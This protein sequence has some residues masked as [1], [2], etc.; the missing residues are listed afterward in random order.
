MSSVF[1]DH[2]SLDAVVAYADGELSLVAYQRAAAHLSRCPGCAADVAEQT[3]A[4]QYLR[5]ACIPRMTGALFDALRSI[6][7]AL[8]A[9]GSGTSAPLMPEQP[10]RP[11][12]HR[13]AVG[14][15]A[16]ESPS[17]GFARLFRFGAGALVTGIAVGAVVLGGA[18][19]PAGT[20]AGPRTPDRT[21]VS[22]PAGFATTVVRAR[23]LHVP[24]VAVPVVAV[25]GVK[26]A[27]VEPAVV[28]AASVH[29]VAR[30]VRTAGR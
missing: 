13:P 6:P 28:E 5:Q 8:P 14:N 12:H 23:S 29:G 18:G 21:A 22:T 3:A 1:D 26:P 2:L 15:P 25:P 20:P 11:T 9:E 16:E 30:T 7:T 19:E 17:S 27:V 4:S 24:V 10:G